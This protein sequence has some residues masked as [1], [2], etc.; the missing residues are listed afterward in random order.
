MIKNK[1]VWNMVFPDLT[2]TNVKD[3]R[4]LLYI[5][6]DNVHS[7]SK[8]DTEAEMDWRECVHSSSPHPYPPSPHVQNDNF[9]GNEDLY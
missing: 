3:E 7:N 1:V 6:D 9:L 2:I 8:D 4:N 5:V